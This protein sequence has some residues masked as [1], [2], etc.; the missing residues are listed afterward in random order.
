MCQVLVN[1][2]KKPRIRLP[3]NYKPVE[4]KLTPV[5]RK[6]APHLRSVSLNI[7]RLFHFLADESRNVPFFVSVVD[8]ADLP[9]K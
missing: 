9:R 3:A 6:D 1:A 2:G 7:K 8:L 4:I 5:K